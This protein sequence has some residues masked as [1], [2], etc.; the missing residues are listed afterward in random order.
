MANLIKTLDASNIHLL[1][2]YL[3]NEHLYTI[4]DSLHQLQIIFN[5]IEKLP[6]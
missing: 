1:K 2:D 3:N 5:T 6:I 4:H